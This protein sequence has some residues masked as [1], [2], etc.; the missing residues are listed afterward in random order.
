[1][2]IKLLYFTNKHGYLQAQLFFN[3]FFLIYYIK[4]K[5]SYLYDIKNKIEKSP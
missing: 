5:L 2:L 1:M 4:G 3:N